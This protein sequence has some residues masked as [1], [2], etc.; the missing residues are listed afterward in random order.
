MAIQTKFPSGML[1]VG[2]EPMGMILHNSPYGPFKFTIKL[3]HGS[4]VGSL[5]FLLF[6]E[7]KALIKYTLSLLY[8]KKTR[9][10]IRPRLFWSDPVFKMR[11]DP[12]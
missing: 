9:M 7:K 2:T 6:D 1:S 11:V 4:K 3:M 5:I 10:Q 8:G 12:G